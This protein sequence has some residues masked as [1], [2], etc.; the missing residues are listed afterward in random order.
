MKNIAKKKIKASSNKLLPQI[1]L[2]ANKSRSIEKL[3]EK[4]KRGGSLEAPAM[5]IEVF[6]SQNPRSM[7]NLLGQIPLVLAEE[8]VT[9]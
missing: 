1:D 9:E 7:S 6:D 8:S 3:R 5:K 4:D 2:L